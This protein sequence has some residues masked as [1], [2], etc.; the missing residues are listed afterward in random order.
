MAGT[1]NFAGASAAGAPSTGQGGAPSAGAPSSA[2]AAGTLEQAGS[3]GTLGSAGAGGAAVAGAATG[4][5]TGTAGAGGGTTAIPAVKFV[6]YI[7]DYSGTWSSWA[8][9][10]D[11]TKVT[12]LNLA[13][14][15]ATTSNGWKSVDGQSDTSIND[16]VKKAHASG[17]KVLA[18]LGGGGT[19]TTVANQY[20]NPAND[21][22]LVANL[23]T[24]LKKYDLDGA[25]IDIEK[26]SKSEVGDNYGTFVSKVVDKL[27]PQG[28][29]V[30]AAVAQYLQ[31]AM[32]DS[33]LHLFDFV[34]IMIYSQKTSDYTSQ[35]NYYIG[36][37]MKK[38][39][40]TLGIISETG[41]RTSPATAKTITTL[42]KS[43]GGAM[44]WEVAGD[45]TGA[46]STYKAIQSSL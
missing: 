25:D 1:G 21:D 6:V 17:A 39:Q 24:F 41:D 5:S 4:G 19:D 36:K 32:N 15:A 28:K 16:I 13:F 38:E 23:D 40:L 20:K 11:F 37:G 42:S 10:I 18:S 33:T 30:T 29:L 9:K 12:H 43:W 8:T 14:F 22:A 27:R 46:D 2:G 31:P 35:L 34:N 45:T 44:L 3:G 7:A 26:E